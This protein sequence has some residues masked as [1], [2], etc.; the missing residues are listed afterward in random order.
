MANNASYIMNQGTYIMCTNTTDRHTFFG[1]A[2]G[3][4][5]EDGK[6]FVQFLQGAPKEW[7]CGY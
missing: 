7:P 4:S 2:M 1:A 6:P 3:T 5:F